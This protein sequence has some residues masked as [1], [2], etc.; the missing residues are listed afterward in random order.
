MKFLFLMD[1][2]ESVIFEKDTTFMLMLGAHNRGHE[3]YY[4]AKDGL[5]LVDGKVYF[6][7]L[8]VTPQAVAHM[9]FKEELRVLKDKVGGLKHR[10]AV[11][12]VEFANK[13]RER[14]EGLEVFGDSFSTRRVLAWGKKTALHRSPMEGARIAWLHKMPASE[15]ENI[16]RI[17]QLNFGNTRSK[18]SSGADVMMGGKVKKTK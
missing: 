6:H 12:I 9:P 13:V 3:T 4:V 14:S 2:L 7:A 16:G 10:W 15:H 8:K 1:P 11:K 5:S 17:L 18:K